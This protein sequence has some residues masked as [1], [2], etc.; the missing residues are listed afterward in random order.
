MTTVTE[1]CAKPAKFMVLTTVCPEIAIFYYPMM[2]M[3]V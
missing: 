3:W 1:K 2:I